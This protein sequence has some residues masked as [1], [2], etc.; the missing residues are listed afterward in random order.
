MA[1][2]TTTGP[3]RLARRSAETLREGGIRALWWQV[4]ATIGLRRLEIH[5]RP[6]E[7]EPALAVEGVKVRPLTRATPTVTAS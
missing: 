3:R 2:T 6:A 7:R 5:C 1:T 4:L